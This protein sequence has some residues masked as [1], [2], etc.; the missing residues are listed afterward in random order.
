MTSSYEIICEPAR[1]P[2]SSENLFSDA[3]PASMAPMMEK[4]PKA[5]TMR[6]PA[7]SGATC[8]GYVRPPNHGASAGTSAPGSSMPPKGTTANTS[9][10][11]ANASHGASR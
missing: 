3:H 10:T 5:K 9:S 8:M 7:S 11:G 1:S 2:P 6:S 4:P